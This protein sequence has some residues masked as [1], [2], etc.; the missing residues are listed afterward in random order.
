MEKTLTG[1]QSP[2]GAKLY[3]LGQE[4]FNYSFMIEITII[5]LSHRVIYLKKKKKAK[6]DSNKE[7]KIGHF[8]SSIII[9]Y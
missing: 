8:S 6:E 1:L 2:T 3:H 5:N 9:L 4:S 7:K